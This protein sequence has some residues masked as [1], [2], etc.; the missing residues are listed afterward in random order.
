MFAFKY[1]LDG[2]EFEEILEFDDS[3]AFAVDFSDHLLDLFLLGFE[4]KRA[5]SDLQLFR[6]D[7]S[8][9]VGV[10]EIKCFLDF[11]LLLFSEL[12]AGLA[13][14]AYRGLCV[15]ERHFGDRSLLVL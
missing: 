10:E 6:V 1:H 5:H 4:A 7:V 11:L 2:H 9:A 8:S 12:R 13:D 15:T 14:C 3:S